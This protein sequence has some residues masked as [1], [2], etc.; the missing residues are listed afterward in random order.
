[1]PVY[2]QYMPRSEKKN[3]LMGGC[4]SMIVLILLGAA[5]MGSVYLAAWIF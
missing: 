2:E 4:F 1:M 5:F 3:Y